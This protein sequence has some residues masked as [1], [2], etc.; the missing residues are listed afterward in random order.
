MGVFDKGKS[1]VGFK[2]SFFGT[3]LVL[4]LSIF[5][6]FGLY[7][8]T[9]SASVPAV[10]TYQGKLLQSG[11]TVS[12]TVG[13]TISLYDDPLSGSILYTASGTTFAPQ[14]LAIPV[15]NGFFSVD[16]GDTGTNALDPQ[17]FKNNTNVYLGV[18]IN[19]E[20]ML[21]RKKLTASPF[22]LN[23]AYLN[24]L[25]ATSSPQN[26]AYIPVADSS[27]NFNFN[28]VSSTGLNVSGNSVLATTTISNITANSGNVT[29]LTNL[30]A[31]YANLN[32][33]S[34]TNI[35][36]VSG[37]F[38]DIFS[39]NLISA[40]ATFSNATSTGFWSGFITALNGIFDNLNWTNG[41]SI[42]TT[43]LNVL[44]TTGATTLAT[45]TITSST[46]GN[47]NVSSNNFIGG[48][49]SV[50]GNAS[51]GTIA[52]GTWNGNVI[53]NAYGGFGADTSNW[54][55]FVKV[56]NGVWSTT[57]I[58]VSD[59]SDG[60]Y[61]AR[62]DGNQ[63]FIGSNNF[64]GDANFASTTFSGNTN[65]TST[66]NFGGT[67]NFD[68]VNT[69]LSTTTFNSSV[70]IGTSTPQDKLHLYGGGLLVDHPADI[71]LIGVISNST[72]IDDSPD[73]Q[74]VGKFAYVVS[75]GNFAVVDVSDKANPVIVGHTTLSRSSI[76]SL[77]ISGNYAYILVGDSNFSVLEVID[78]SKPSSPVIVNTVDNDNLNGYFGYSMIDISGKY[79]YVV[80]DQSGFTI[81]DISNPLNISFLGHINNTVDFRPASVYVSGKYAYIGNSGTDGLYVVDISNPLSPSIISS[82]PSSNTQ[83]GE[84]SIYV[85][86]KYVYLGVYYVGMDIF[87]VSNPVSPALVGTWNGVTGYVGNLK[88]AGNYAYIATHNA[89][90]KVI[91]ITDKTN[92]VSIGSHS[93]AG[94]SPYS[95]A[96]LDVSGKNIYVANYGINSFEVL[97]L[98]AADISAANIGNVNA[99]ALTVSEDLSVG[100]NLTIRNG[101][102]IGAGGLLSNGAL[103][104]NVSSTSATD[105][106][107]SV[108]S[109]FSTS[110]LVVG[111]D[112]LVTVGNALYLSDISAPTNTANSLYS[113]NGN[114][115]WNGGVVGGGAQWGS[116]PASSTYYSVGNV[117]VG[118]TAPQEKLHVSDGTLLVDGPLTP[119]LLKQYVYFGGYSPNS[120][121]VLGNNA[122]V[123]VDNTGLQIFDV[124]NKTNPIPKT[125]TNYGNSFVNLKVV[126]KYA[127]GVGNGVMEIF[128]VS[129]IH[130]Q[131]RVSQT[132]DSYFNNFFSV[133]PTL[134]LSG[135]FAYVVGQNGFAVVDIS[136]PISPNIVGRNAAIGGGSIQVSGKYAYVNNSSTFTAV[137][138]SDPTNPTVVQSLSVPGNASSIR[139]VNNLA[140]VGTQT[141]GL[142]VVDISDPSNMSIVGTETSTAAYP[143]FSMAVSGK[144]VY[145]VGGTMGVGTIL[146]YDIS[147]P[148]SPTVVT[149]FSSSTVGY[150]SDL[151]MDIS[152]KY[153]YTVDR[154][155][156]F[157]SIFDM[158]G[159]DISNANIGSA[160]VSMLTVTENVD[161]GNNLNIKNSLN[162]GSGGIFTNGV[163]AV[164]VSSTDPN[165][166]IFSVGNSTNSALFSIGADG[167]ARAGGILANLVSSTG[168]MFTNAT[169][170]YFY[171]DS[172]SGYWNGYAI[173]VANGGTG[174]STL[175]DYSNDGGI[176]FYNYDNTQL[177]VDPSNFH[178]DIYGQML[179]LGT[180][181]PSELLSVNGRIFLASTTAPVTTTDKLYNVGGQLYWSGNAIGGQWDSGP[182]SSLNYTAGSISLGTSTPSGRLRVYDGGLVVDGPAHP[183]FKSQVTSTIFNGIVSV[184]VSNN[185]AYVVNNSDHSLAVVD[186]SSASSPVL[187]SSIKDNVK[188]N[189]AF[190]IVVSGKYAYVLNG[191]DSGLAVVNI[192]NP[193]SL[194][195]DGYASSSTYLGSATAMTLSGKYLYVVQGSGLS[196]I[197]ISNSSHP[198]FVKRFD[199]GSID[200]EIQIVGDLA[201]VTA[202]DGFHVLDI[203]DPLNPVELYSGF[204]YGNFE[205][206][207]HMAVSGKYGYIINPTG[208]NVPTG[209]VVLDLSSS[210]NPIAISS[211]TVPV[212]AYSDIHV[213]GN[214]LYIDDSTDGK[215]SVLDVSDKTNPRLIGTLTD[216]AHLQNAY[217]WRTA[218]VGKYA[219]ITNRTNKSLNILDLEGAEIS[220]ANIGNIATDALTVWDSLDVGNNLSIRNGLNVGIGGLFSNGAL[221][222]TVSTTISTSSVFSVGTNATSSMLSVM[223]DGTVL[224][225]TTTAADVASSY[226]LLVDGNTGVNGFIQA[227]SFITGTTTLDLAETYPVNLSC[228]N[229][230]TCPGDGDVVCV[231]ATVVAGVK[232]CSA[233]LSDKIIGI[234]SAKPGFLLGGGDLSDP[235]HNLGTV[236]VALSGRVPVKVSSVNGT[237]VPGDKLTVSN[238]DGVAMKAV[239]EAPVVAIALE[240]FSSSGQGTVLAFVN[241]GWQ[242]NLYQALSIDQSAATLMVGS[243]VTPYNLSVSGE[244]AMF[245]NV[246]NKMVFNTTALF[247]SNAT[248]DHAFIL[249]AANFGTSTDKYLLS[250]RS[251]N[252]SKFS[253]MSNGDI[254]SSGNLYAA[255]AIF[256]TSTNPGDLAERVDIATDENVEPGDVLVV[257]DNNPDT[258]RKSK[259]SNEQAVAGVVSTNPSIIVGNGKTSYTA[260]MAM[261]G[262]VPLKVSDENGKI[263]RGDLL[264]TASSTGFAMKYD[265]KKDTG[266]NMVGIIGVALEPFN[267]GQGKI[268]ALIRTGWVNS[269]FETITKLKNNIDQLATASGIDLNNPTQN[270]LAVNSNSSGQLVYNG[271]NLNLRGNSL[272]NVASIVGKNNVWSIDE[273]GHFITKITTADGEKDMFAIQSQSSEF[274]FSSSSQLVAGTVSINFDQ[275]EQDLIDFSQPIKI[276]ITLTSGEAKGIYVSEKN[277]QGFVVKELDNGHSNATFDWMVVAKR[278]EVV[279][280]APVVDE[281]TNSS[282]SDQSSSSVDVASSTVSSTVVSGSTLPA[283]ST[284]VEPSTTS[285]PDQTPVAPVVAPVV[286]NTPPAP[287]NDTP[288]P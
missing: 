19:G 140:F 172:Y 246:L 99:N 107:F 20:M 138:I 157:L 127:Y 72:D 275:S 136:N 192:S 49:L 57:T 221:A 207:N 29:G 58:Y 42:G 190:D 226:K 3:S 242:N 205:T 130:D 248:G 88:V 22:A 71:S 187:V 1:K 269:R 119:K 123:G 282:Q 27:G 83:P 62:L 144:Y 145:A 174:N 241:L 23:A 240:G 68:G 277:S 169:S 96:S 26:S 201:Y 194:T 64:S 48:L 236:K 131:V 213:A 12:S 66:T 52:S 166:N 186:I 252:E 160:S 155:N 129:N 259:A 281:P 176:L 146:A 228:A 204:V 121:Q 80:G 142:A 38:S 134:Y 283:E 270:S 208:Y 54:T 261:V 39:A 92:P 249:N 18:F 84:N 125:Q 197:D 245:N 206:Y 53:S 173:S 222:V 35:N 263:A 260:V 180:S 149:I 102:N 141:N 137:D 230:G 33:V 124:S 278:K 47:L 210:T 105:I 170:T 211:T 286:E 118:T 183:T 153:L 77:K 266:E 13:M 188:F 74:V 132:S 81:L 90:I 8:N 106:I 65:F 9:Q 243:S 198:R 220:T 227:S 117:G 231:D 63:T 273:K 181:T 116:G 167:T 238:L 177:S 184:A 60:N 233:S 16:I 179:G 110:S 285:A 196:L 255:S 274:V 59:L 244:F 151:S 45:T 120:V 14:N 288:L 34:S 254:Y 267:E 30:G 5:G 251:N 109:G 4:I 178:W 191:A 36:S 108:G 224:I 193:S 11:A 32:N 209:V 150:W 218:V 69:F 24:G 10:I 264:V 89:G 115:V 182:S 98:S 122:Y 214:Y 114:L 17:I 143:I 46:I 28:N 237:I 94:F 41:T 76:S 25:T 100:N 147:N 67:N 247:E 199:F 55:G 78:I 37:M 234:V 21:P 15:V 6:L 152:G 175:D 225:N 40:N 200:H 95:S 61:L 85:S 2:P 148:L 103:S 112:G 195:I 171:S 219:Y 257:D 79:A 87:D 189:G 82:V 185:F 271:G 165:L 212:D 268:L 161:F 217:T 128:D 75:N 133:A 86:G 239:G 51:F 7:N 272:L 215:F 156:Q 126:G 113:V 276:N 111:G 162:V 287:V 280:V 256:G 56:N 139:V 203:S 284:V 101:L 159:A 135:K 164:N 97:S 91:D 279:E 232:K 163:L 262:R 154:G 31:D 216:T 104:V 250:L 50:V 235:N 44:T 258:Y 202:E 70:G 223:G 73:I 158:G 93:I 229:S 265:P 43:S 253:V 168:G